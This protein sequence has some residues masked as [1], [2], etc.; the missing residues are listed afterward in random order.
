LQLHVPTPVQTLQVIAYLVSA[1]SIIAI[2]MTRQEALRRT[3]AVN[4]ELAA[5]NAGLQLAVSSRDRVLAVVSHDLKSP[6]NAILLSADL[7]KTA[8][9]KDTQTVERIGSTIQ[10]SA[11]RMDA[12][13]RDLLDLSV[14]ERG[15]I[16][17][18]RRPRPVSEILDQTLLLMRPQ[19]A[20][21]G[22]TLLAN[23]PADLPPIDVDCSRLR[24][25]EANLIG[26]AIT[27]TPAGGTVAIEA[28]ALSPAEVQFCV[29]DSGPGIAVEALP[30]LFDRTWMAHH[31]VSQQGTGLGLSIVKAIVAASGRRTTPTWGPRSAL[32]CRRR[33]RRSAAAPLPLRTSSGPGRRSGPGRACSTAPW[34]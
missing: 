30:H 24:Q 11:Q 4:A 27:F 14:I 13:V 34:W 29:R 15:I 2:A 18:N 31:H 12:L 7:L 5:A 6:L 20:H 33:R 9:G 25:A 28:H 32:P 19:A 1:A 21:K 23:V 26:N 3:E 10:A 16:S 8:A 22:I 17:L